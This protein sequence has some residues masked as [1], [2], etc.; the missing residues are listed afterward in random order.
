MFCNSM[1][2]LPDGRVFVNGGTSVYDAFLG[3]IRSSIFD[4][5]T[6]TFTDVPTNM[7]HG[8]WYPTVTLLSDGRVMTFSGK[9]RMRATNKTVEIYT[10]GSGWSPPVDAGWTPP[11]YPR[12]HL[13]PN[14]KVFYSGPSATSRLFNP[15]NQSWTT[16]DTT[17]LGADANLRQL[18]S[19]AFDA[20]QQLRPEGD[21]FRWRDVGDGHDRN[22]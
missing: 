19:A 11:L 4:P 21:D 5:A 15:S 17:K 3:E 22:H 7:A 8:R 1:T 13:L 10:V 18:G 12:L 20:G 2:V 16:V 6:N 14:G 9:T